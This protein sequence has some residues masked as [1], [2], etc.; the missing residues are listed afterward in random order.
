VKI[1]D[2]GLLLR[3]VNYGETS[4]VLTL[5]TF[6][7]GLKSFIFK[8]AKKKKGAILLPLAFLEITYFER[9]EN[10]LGQLTQADLLMHFNDVLFDPRKSAVL[11]FMCDIL[12][13][14]IREENI[15]QQELFLFLSAELVELDK[16]P[17][18]ANYPLYFM[19]ALTR[20]LGVEPHYDEDQPLF[21]DMNEGSF[22]RH[23]PKRAQMQLTETEMSWLA[24]N[25]LK[26]KDQ[27]LAHNLPRNERQRLIRIL[28]DYYSHHLGNFSTPKSLT[29]L[30]EVF[31]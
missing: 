14:V 23:A 8:G 3:K 10:Q 25:F 6:N 27:I 5:F 21:F 30:E 22:T 12:N 19:M 29:I 28:L 18:E 9:V 7:H 15:P 11:F 4:L 20:F 2:K 16:S 24:V 17:F 1:T 26:S 13:S 31:D